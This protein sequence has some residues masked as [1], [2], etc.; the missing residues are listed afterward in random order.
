[1]LPDHISI[2]DI[3]CGEGTISRM[4]M[5][6]KQG[7]TYQGIDIKARPTCAIPY[8]TFDGAH[9]PYSDGTFDAVQFVDVLH[10][11]DNIKE[12]LQDSLRTSKKY[13]IIKDHLYKSSLDFSIL[14]FM[15]W[16]GN[17][18]HGVEVIYNF[19]K[20]AY[21]MQLFDELGLEVVTYNKHI[22]L[23]PSVFNLIFGRELHFITVLKKKNS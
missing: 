12:L 17:A 11:T 9:I 19:K 2:L 7:I 23:Y 4:I 5:D 8:Q 6:S 10:H 14:K 1:M 16:V 13:L 3:G 21:W 20:E 22:R 15:D 18:P